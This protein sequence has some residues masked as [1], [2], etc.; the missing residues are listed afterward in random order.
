MVT[1]LRSGRVAQAIAWAPAVGWAALLFFLS[2]ETFAASSTGRWVDAIV[3]LF[4][5]QATPLLVRDVHFLVRKLA[6]VGAYFVFALLLDRGFRSA[7]TVSTPARLV[8]AF[9]IAAAYSLT[10][11]AHQSFVRGRTA[12]IGDCGFDGL[13]AALASLFLWMRNPQEEEISAYELPGTARRR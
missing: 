11:E 2:T 4:W 13:G 3:R 1:I 8:A 5:P 7:T 10:D 6:H 9:A 12:T